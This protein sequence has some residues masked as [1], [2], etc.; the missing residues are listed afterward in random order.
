[1]ED[2]IDWEQAYHDK[3]ANDS[4]TLY[5]L[6]NGKKEKT[7]LKILSH[8]EIEKLNLKNLSEEEYFNSSSTDKL[9]LGKIMNVNEEK[10]LHNN[11]KFWMT[12]KR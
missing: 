2:T 4:D 3:Y 5:A 7:K 6:F 12:K 1:M 11:V 9:H 10:R 8:S